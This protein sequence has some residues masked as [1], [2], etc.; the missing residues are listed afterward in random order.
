M[1]LALIQTTQNQLQTNSLAK[2]LKFKLNAKVII[3]DIQYRLINGQTENIKHIELVQGSFH[4]VYVKFSDEQAG[5]KAMSEN[6]QKNLL[7]SY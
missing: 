5:L 6:R 3:Q 1:L 2:L 7:G 4:K